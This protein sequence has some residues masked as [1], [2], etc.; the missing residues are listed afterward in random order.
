VI[1]HNAYVDFTERSL[2]LL[3][4]HHLDSCNL[5]SSLCQ[6]LEYSIILIY[7]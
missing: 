4:A 1:G 7:I 5:N 3:L 6:A 2:T